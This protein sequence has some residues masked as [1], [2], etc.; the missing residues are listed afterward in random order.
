VY[1]GPDHLLK[2][3]WAHTYVKAEVLEFINLND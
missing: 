3:D 2:R 1:V